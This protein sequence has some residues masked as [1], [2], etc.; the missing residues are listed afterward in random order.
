MSAGG[1][2]PT[3]RAGVLFQPVIRFAGEVSGAMRT[4]LCVLLLACAASAC[5]QVQ[6]PPPEAAVGPGERLVQVRSVGR[7]EVVTSVTTFTEGATASLGRLL[8]DA[9]RGQAV[10]V[11]SHEFWIAR[12]GRVHE[13]IGSPIDIDGQRFTIVGVAP[14]SESAPPYPK[15]WIPSEH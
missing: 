12:F 13:A 11:I 15:V 1:A 7:G 2:G 5:G 9:D 4:I 3:L 14:E 10:A 8:T 6:L